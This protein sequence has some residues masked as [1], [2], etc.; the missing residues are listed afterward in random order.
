MKNILLVRKTVKFYVYYNLIYVIVFFI[1]FN[2]LIFNTP[3][4]INIISEVDSNNFNQ[5]DMM[6]NFHS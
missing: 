4:G 5:E 1:I 2:I 6:T 3:D